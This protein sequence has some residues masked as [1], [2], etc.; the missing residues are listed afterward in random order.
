MIKSRYTFS[1]NDRETAEQLGKALDLPSAVALLLLRQ[2]IR[3]Q[4]QA[5]AFFSP[6]P[7]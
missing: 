7:I 2:G 6:T 3:T 4:A 1:K 5:H